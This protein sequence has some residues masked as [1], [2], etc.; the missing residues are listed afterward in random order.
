MGVL[1]AE[2]PEAS[3]G[4]GWNGSFWSFGG[5]P[6]P[7]SPNGPARKRRYSRGDRPRAGRAD[8]RARGRPRG[9]AG[10]T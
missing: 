7:G 10:D 8:A 2:D 3:G 1:S 9:R 4:K 6:G 5:L